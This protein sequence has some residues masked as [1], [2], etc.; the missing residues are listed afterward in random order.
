M[1]YSPNP[2]PHVHLTL[3]CGQDK[4][5]IHLGCIFNACDSFFNLRKKKI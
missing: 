2:T 3:I 5:T 1:T 4:K